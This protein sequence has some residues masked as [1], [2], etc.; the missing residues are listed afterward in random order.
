M[1]NQTVNTSSSV[2][3]S[4]FHGRVRKGRGGKDGEER[5][6]RKELKRRIVGAV[7]TGV[8]NEYVMGVVGVVGAVGAVNEH[9]DGRQNFIWFKTRHLTLSTTYPPQRRRRPR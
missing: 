3:L 9:V 7:W 1:D 4:T 2:R 8:V 5:T 6:G